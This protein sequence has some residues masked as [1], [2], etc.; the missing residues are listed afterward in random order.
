MK[1][2]DDP[3]RILQYIEGGGGQKS[4]VAE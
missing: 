3:I 4:A 2:L 1:H